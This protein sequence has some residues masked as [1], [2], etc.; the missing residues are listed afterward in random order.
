MCAPGR[1]P[2]RFRER[3]A[4]PRQRHPVHVLTCATHQVGASN[5]VRIGIEIGGTFTD[6]VAVSDAGIQVVKVSSTPAAPEDGVFE[7]LDRLGR[8]LDGADTLVHGSTVATNALLERKGGRTA[9]VTTKGFR[10]ILELQRELK[11]RNYDLRYARTVPLVPRERVIEAAERLDA[12]GAVVDALDEAALAADLQGLF[13]ATQPESLAV[14]L[15]HA[16]LNPAHERRVREI[17]LR[18]RPGLKVSLSCEIMP[19][20][21]EY[22]RAS[23][24]VMN[25]YL[26]PVVDAYLGRLQARLDARGFRGRFYVMQSN[27]GMLPADRSRQHAVRT[28]VS[29]ALLILS[30]MV[31]MP[32]IR[33]A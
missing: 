12:T 1:G 23:T 19:E 2:G 25:A 21:R 20:Y 4:D 26:A 33:L 15:L 10:D 18:L 14:C 8:A 29:A 16:Y 22:E 11:S 24:T 5:N 17:A 31:K 27:G 13:D 30:D 3:A 7:A 28:L 32:C 9:L 6:L